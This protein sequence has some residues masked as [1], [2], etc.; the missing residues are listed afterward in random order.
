M[1]FNSRLIATWVTLATLILSSNAIPSS[2]MNIKARHNSLHARRDAAAA[3]LE[4][5]SIVDVVVPSLEERDV[6]V[7]KKK[8]STKKCPTKSSN[9]SNAP[10]ANVENAP[11]AS[12]SA[13]AP[14]ASS[15]QSRLEKIQSM[16]AF[17][18]YVYDL[19]DCISTSQMKSDFKTIASKNART[20]ITFGYCPSQDTQSDYENVIQAAEDANLNIIMLVA[21]LI[22]SSNTLYGGDIPR[23]NHIAQAIINKPNNVLALAMGDEPLYDNDFGSP[24]ALANEINSIK[25]T[26]KSAGLDIPIS[27]SDMAFGWQQAGQTKSSSVVAQAVDFFMVNTFPYFSQSASWGGDSNAW[28]AFTSDISFFEGLADGRPILVTQTGWPSNEEEFSPN[29]NSVDASTSSEQ[30]YWELLDGHCEDFFKSKNIAW[31]WR[32]WNDSIEGWGVLDA[33][34][35]FKFNVDGVKTSC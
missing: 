18:G 2:S 3:A 7:R 16:Y 5:K 33:S 6:V 10:V 19:E 26:F 28:S 21:T 15:S 1:L 12:S 13:P 34:G 14:S 17:A 32:D 20:V 9:S 22:S 24:Q 27:I 35:N 23:A 30:A 25:G 8:R 31:M 11:S 29:S 4:K